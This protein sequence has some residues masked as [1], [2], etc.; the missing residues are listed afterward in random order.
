MSF[1]Q[2]VA[3]YFRHRP[4]IWVNGMDLS[5][6]GGCYAWRSRVSDCRR[7]GMTIENR[8]RPS[9]GQTVSEYRFVPDVRAS[10][11]MDAD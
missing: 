7:L 11:G 8:Q 1:V 2:A 6:V 3:E 5:H 10:G 4:N 9:H